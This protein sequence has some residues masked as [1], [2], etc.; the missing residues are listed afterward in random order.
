MPGMRDIPRTTAEWLAG[1][2]AVTRREIRE[3]QRPSK[4]SRFAVV[5]RLG[6]AELTITEHGVTLGQHGTRIT[7]AEG[8]LDSHAS[9]IGAAEG[10]ITNAEGRLDSHASRIGAAEGRITNAEGRLD[11][12]ASR[13]GAAENGIAG[14]KTSM[15]QSKAAT[16]ILADYILDLIAYMRSQ[17][18]NPPPGPI[19]SI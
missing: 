17:G 16:R 7:N 8:R 5:L 9:R 19:T 18:M 15:T 11:S 2:E 3:L 13:I 14:L 1:R 6:D 10:R 12:H 4:E